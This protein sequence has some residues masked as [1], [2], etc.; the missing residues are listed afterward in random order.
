MNELK[1]LFDQAR[2]GTLPPDFDRWEIAD[3]TGRTAAHVAASYGH[4]PAGFDRWQIAGKK[5]WTVAHEAAYFD[6]LPLDFGQW[7]LM[8]DYF[9]L[10][11]ADV[12]QKRIDGLK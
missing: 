11:V 8:D 6:H 12:V 7:D 5:G 3:D 1:K 2:E 10:T 9:G 4:L